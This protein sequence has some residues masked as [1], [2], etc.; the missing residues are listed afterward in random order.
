MSLLS[1]R[2]N[3]KQ[4]YTESGNSLKKTGGVSA[5]KTVKTYTL[6]S[7]ELAT[8]ERLVIKHSEIAEKTAIHHLNPRNQEDLTIESVSDIIESIRKSGVDTEGVAVLN[9]ETGKYELLDASRRRFCCIETGHDLPIW[10]LKKISNTDARALIMNTQNVKQFSKREKGLS[11]KVLMEEQGFTTNEELAKHLGVSTETV[12]TE[13]VAASIDKNIIDL[14][15][16]CES[17]PNSFYPKLSKFQ[18][19][20]TDNLIQDL[21]KMVKLTKLGEV[22]VTEKHEIIMGSIEAAFNKIKAIKQKPTWT[23]HQLAE[24]K[25]KKKSAKLK[26]SPDGRTVKIE[27]S[28]LGVGVISEIEEFISKKLKEASK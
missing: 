27:L 20:L 11:N 13:M 18:K 14:F 16:A 12:R 15:P 26:R 17:I 6:K 3:N 28:R 10:A 2:G 19:Q 24:F 5:Q 1:K 21:V 9:Q 8:A 22:P 4:L 25:D 23:E 7:G